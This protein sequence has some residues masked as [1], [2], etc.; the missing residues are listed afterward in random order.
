[1]THLRLDTAFEFGDW[2]LLLDA[3]KLRLRSIVGDQLALLPEA[4]AHETVLRI[5]TRVLDCVAALDLLQGALTSPTHTT[6]PLPALVIPQPKETF[7]SKAQHGNKEAKKP[8]KIRPPP[9]PPQPAAMAVAPP[10]PTL[11]GLR[12]KRW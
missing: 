11:D 1:M 3:V 6:P 12:K 8:K 7:M 5:R 10:A 2:L 9:G 4:T